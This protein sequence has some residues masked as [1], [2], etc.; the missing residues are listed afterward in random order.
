MIGV[1]PELFG[2]VADGVTDDQPAIALA[3]ARAAA[4]GCPVEFSARTYAHATP[5]L[6]PS[7]V[8]LIGTNTGSQVGGRTK[9]KFTGSGAAA[10]GPANRNANT[11][12]VTLTGIHF[13]GG[14]AATIGLDLYRTSYSRIED[15]SVSGVLANSGVGVQFDANN[16]SG[17]CYF[18]VVD[19]VKVDGC[20]VGVKF[21]R[22]ANANSWRG[23]KI[24]NG[25]TGIHL[26]GDS[27]AN[28][29]LAVDLEDASIQHVYVDSPANVFLGTHMEVAPIGFY[30][31]SNGWDTRRFGTTIATTID[32]YFIDESI[33]SCSL[34]HLT[35]DSAKLGLDFTS[36]VS[37][38]GSVRTTLTID[39][40]PL[41]S[42]AESVVNLFSGIT[43]AGARLA[44]FPGD[45]SATS[46]V[47][48]DGRQSTIGITDRSGAPAATPGGGVLYVEAGALKYR[49]SSGTITTLAS[50]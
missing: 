1:P 47:R 25:G 45:G 6:Y 12:N 44:V 8:S 41:T 16:E 13:D 3:I 33:R 18:N 38:T 49:G 10:V 32:D 22:M 29:F 20:P 42:E 30:I 15:C 7:H 50:A 37:K 11:V 23:G 48:L 26:E 35:T 14:S 4:E 21:T 28:V 2:A 46:T 43:A 34:D 31:T 27:V 19:N 36:V 40:A 5:I 17:Q 39:P 9:L 24:G